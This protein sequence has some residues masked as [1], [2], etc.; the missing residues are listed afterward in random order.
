MDDEWGADDAEY[1]DNFCANCGKLLHGDEGRVKGISGW[2]CGKCI[3]VINDPTRK[4]P[5]PVMV[6][7]HIIGNRR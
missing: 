2:V 7:G 6:H 4:G 5:A 1:A 3:A